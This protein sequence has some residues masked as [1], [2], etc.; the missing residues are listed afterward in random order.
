MAEG[1][2]SVETQIP[3]LESGHTLRPEQLI[4]TAPCGIGLQLLFRG[5]FWKLHPFSLPL[6]YHASPLPIPVAPGST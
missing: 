4:A 2:R 6:P 3:L 5:V 1:L